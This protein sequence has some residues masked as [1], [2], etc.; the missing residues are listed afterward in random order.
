MKRYIIIWAFL[1]PF[2]ALAQ[3]GGYDPA[4]PPQPNWPEDDESTFFTVFCEAIPDG[5]GQFGN[6]A[7]KKVKPGKQASIYAYDHN[8]CYFIAWKDA[9]GNTVSTNRSYS[10][11]MPDKDVKF[12]AIYSYNPD[13]PTDPV[14][15]AKYMLALKCDPVVAGSF[16][17]KDQ[18]VIEG[19]TQNLHAYSNS[20]FR[21]INWTDENGYVV[22]EQQ[23]LKFLMP[24]HNT[25]L[26]AHF[27]YAPEEPQEPG[28]NLW[29]ATSGELIMDFFTPGRLTDAMTTM[30]GGS[31]NRDKATTLTVDGTVTYNDW[32]FAYYFKKLNVVD[33]SRVE[34]FTYV[35]SGRW[36]DY[37][38]LQEIELPKDI[39]NIE[40]RAFQG[41]TGLVRFNC[42]AAVP[43]TLGT[44]VFK[45]VPTDMVVFVPESSVDLYKA[46]P[47]WSDFDIVPLLSKICTLEVSLP[48]DYADGRYK[49]MLLEVINVKSGQKYK[50]VITDHQ[51]YTFPTLI[52]KTSYKA[53]VKNQRGQIAGETEVVEIDHDLETIAFSSV[54]VPKTVS[55]LV[56][57]SNGADVTSQVNVAW[58]DANNNYLSTGATLEA[59]LPGQK[60]VYTIT[61][62][63]TLGRQYV[64][65]VPVTYTVGEDNVII[66]T[67]SPLP[68]LN[69]SGVW[70]AYIKD[71][72]Q[73]LSMATFAISQVLNGKYTTVQTLTVKATDTQASVTVFNAPT[74]ITV[75]A[76]DYITES[77]EVA[78]LTNAFPERFELKPAT[79]PVVNVSFTYQP[80]VAQGETPQ[81][82]NYYEDY[83][84]VS[85]TL[86]NITREAAIT[87]FTA[88][89][90]KLALPD[91][92]HEGDLVRI[93]VKSTT[94]EFSDVT[95]Q[96]KVENNRITAVIPIV[97]HGGIRARFLVTD[98]TAVEGLLFDS[99]GSLVKHGVY[100]N[101]NPQALEGT[102]ANDLTFSNLA[103]GTY[104]L[105]TMGQSDFFS[106]MFDL[107]RFS[108][109]GLQEG[110]D[111]VKNV[112]KV[113][114]G[115]I[116]GVRNVVVPVFDEKKFYYTGTN[117]SFTVNKANVIQGNYLTMNARLDFNDEVKANVKEVEL[118]IPL[119]INSDFVNGSLMIG[120]SLAGSH[121]FQYVDTRVKSDD[122]DANGTGFVYSSG[123]HSLT[124][125]LGESY[126]ERVKFCVVPLKRGNFTPTAYVR[127]KLGDKTI[128]Q[129]IGSAA[130]TVNDV[131]I[132]TPSL[133]SEPYVHVDG[134]APGF[135]KVSIWEDGIMIGYTEALADGYWSA[136]CYMIGTTNL[137]MHQI[138]ATIETKEGYQLTSERRFVEY[139]ISSIQGKEVEMSFFNNGVNRTVVV[140]FDLEHSKASQ[141]SYPFQGGTEFVF[142]ANLTNNSP[143]LVD[144]CVV[145]VFTN[146]HEWI[147]LP[148][149]YIPNRD[150]W[151]AH[152]KFDG[153]TM[154]IG[155]RVWVDSDVSDEIDLDKTLYYYQNQVNARAMQPNRVANAGFDIQLEPVGDGQLGTDGVFFQGEASDYDLS[156]FAADT[157]ELPTIEKQKI[158]VHVAQDGSFLVINPT[159]G[160]KVWGVKSN[161]VSTA[162]MMGPNKVRI[163]TDLNNE[164]KQRIMVLS[165]LG[166]MI[167]PYTN[168]NHLEYMWAEYKTS[169]QYYAANPP[170]TPAQIAQ[171]K[172]CTRMMQIMEYAIYNINEITQI[173]RHINDL[174]SYVR[175]GLE[176]VNEWQAFADRIL[177]CNG[178]DD[179]QARALNWLSQRNMVKHGWQYIS[180]VEMAINAAQ[181]LL[182]TLTP[183]MAYYLVTTASDDA[184]ESLYNYANMACDFVMTFCT[185]VFMQ[186][187]A[188]SH[189][190]MRKAKRDKNRLINCGYTMAE[191]VE[192]K[193][194]LSLPYPIVE[195]IIDPSGYVYEGVSSNRLEGVTA[196]A[197]YKRTYEDMYGDLQQE[198][199][200]WDAENYGQ[201]NPLYTDDQGQYAW[202]VPQG[203]WQ[204]KFEKEGYQTTY[205]EWLPVPPPQLDVN[206]AMKQ[207]A[208]PEI[209]KA[210]AFEAGANIDGGVE[211]TFSKYM[212]PDMLNADNII[213]KGVKDGEQTLIEDI[214]YSCP[215]L[216]FAIEGS[217]TKYAKKVFAANS[218]I[219]NYDEIIVIVNRAVESYAGIQMMETYQQTIDIEKQITAVKVDEQVLVGYEGSIM[220]QVAALPTEAAAGKTI[221]VTTASPAIATLGDGEVESLEL[222]LD[223]N[224]M[225]EVKV[226]GALF[227]TTA[228]NFEVIDEE[229]KGQTMVNV[230]DPAQLEPVKAPVASRIS[231]TAVY[232][233]QTVA[234]SCET[235]EAV[236]YYTTD[237]TC[238]CDSETRM[239]YQSPIAINQPMTLKAM[240]VGVNGSQSDVLE[241]NFLIRQTSLVL[242]LAEGWNWVSHNMANPFDL[243]Q[244]E[245]YA[246]EVRTAE[247]TETTIAAD[248]ALKL[249][250]AQAT[251]MQ[252]GGDQYNPTA[253]SIQL[254]AG[255]N[256]LGYPV[257]QELTLADALLHLEA[258]EG[259]V[260]T[261]LTGGFAEY[262]DGAWQ[263][264][265]LTMIPGQGYLYK[266]VGEKAFIYNV[267]PTA[268]ARAQRAQQPRRADTQWSVNPHLYH[269]MMPVTAQLKVGDTP[270]DGITFTIAAFVGNECRGVSLAKDGLHYLPV[271]GNTEGET[272]TL[273]VFDAKGNEIQEGPSYSFA[274]VAD[275]LGSALAPYVISV[276]LRGDV[277][278]DG[279]VNIAD[280]A[281]VL[282]IMAGN[283]SV[284]GDV[285]GDNVVNIADVAA[286]LNIMA[287][288]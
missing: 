233:G 288:N 189:N 276:K 25:T 182:N 24:S 238:P 129:P 45:D 60:V 54:L 175:Y 88:N 111:Y 109:T 146:N 180:S 225:V 53:F 69:I 61:L 163:A 11:T 264:S 112:I 59:Q 57:D 169:V 143:E 250:I 90:P 245:G 38:D 179:P 172:Y 26:T 126:S 160:G 247:T 230:V 190:H 32:N 227:G 210:R 87:S 246:T 101:F 284:E 157:L 231:G 255:W 254:K 97:Q 240:S 205:S 138:Y 134:N 268:N 77:Y 244:L 141:P 83:A 275:V 229:V 122:P 212:N 236:I 82:Q 7:N 42:Y 43:P 154:P 133:V 78:D 30:V 170:T 279:V 156:L 252:L 103:D 47:G 72:E 85:Y 159:D 222:Q 120:K 235:E 280:V 242:D 207:L 206:I 219:G 29:D 162:R 81:V 104:T 16:N 155:V 63:E 185:D 94:G 80:T 2:L 282:N 213:I 132:W 9:E 147:E 23:D 218:S 12:Y 277:N 165:E 28:T 119:P 105:I 84:N 52:R 108:D 204:V 221:R 283:S 211:I 224:G 75:S 50:Y 121:Q 262:V 91:D 70:K 181:L 113:E 148:A 186:N 196:T 56:K 188:A 1:L 31:S 125:Q 19:T 265:L 208:Q 261:N 167:T 18:K 67:L 286:V 150:R 137:S 73:Q 226:N 281:A 145:R 58:A 197:Y 92:V 64:E 4:N 151:V 243:G 144:S 34:G 241:W 199:V 93:T 40:S 234:L 237:G 135:S 184:L 130:F 253:T 127:F 239:V 183:S 266:S 187:K 257:D 27:E 62:P 192:K 17:F 37:T 89:Y 139:N 95:V 200:K 164:L 6:D 168:R 115:Y 118:V 55:L 161:S 173:S 8:G 260:I 271:Y 166:Q 248:A 273:R 46:A 259:D 158:M 149:K 36:Q 107:S 131:T 51:K 15:T 136:E 33:L 287:G 110:I 142:T 232:R 278:N 35:P 117:T 22:G 152:G 194:D 249:K 49:N 98:N 217:T 274:F 177:P 251:Q 176:D 14:M 13:S 65:P 102:D 79:G 178:L 202:D 228:L 174:L 68:T 220:L 140:N 216:E 153:Q 48:D 96:G 256:W 128:T 198:V 10:F 195:P 201:E 272:V 203:L 215:D 193:L 267:V 100:A 5:A 263:G 66:V 171:Q 116:K 191:T 214:S 39:S 285:N 44:D 123:E 258:Q 41:C 269:S 71:S 223:A 76:N 209:I 99:K 86:Y 114:S 3:T 270:L 21:F 124:V 74:V 106:S 20:G